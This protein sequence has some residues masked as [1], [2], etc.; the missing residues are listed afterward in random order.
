ME[1]KCEITIGDCLTALSIL[2]SFGLF[3]W[4]L[5]KS[6]R[7]HREDTRS[8]WF[9]DVVVMPNLNRISQL[10]EEVTKNADDYVKQLNEMFKSNN[11][12]QDINKSISKKSKRV[13]ESG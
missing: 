1:F 9:L 11:G 6:R 8:R 4:Q 13:E 10:Y 3:I 5:R 12:A 7:D 2:I